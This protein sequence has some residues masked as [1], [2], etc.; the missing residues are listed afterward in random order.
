[1]IGNRTNA[2][3]GAVSGADAR[4]TYTANALNQYMEQTVPARANIMGTAETGTV[5]TVNNQATSRF[6]KYFQS[7]AGVTNS[8]SAAYPLVTVVG[9]LPGGGT[10]GTDV[11]ATSSGHVFVAKTPEQFSYDDDGNLL[12]DGRWS[13]EWDAENRLIGMETRTNLPAA[14]P[15]L[16]LSFAY[17]YMSRRVGKTVHTN[18]SGSW[19]LTSDSSFLYDGWAMISEISYLPSQMQTNQSWFVYGLDLSGT[20]QGAGTIGGLL[21]TVRSGDPEP[22]EGFYAYDA[23]GNVTD[24]GIRVSPSQ[25]TLR[26]VSSCTILRAWQDI[27]EL[28]QSIKGH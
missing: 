25:Y 19:I 6:G 28:R 4:R 26:A 21:A 2:Y 3:D 8:S 17:D 24:L 11:V 14:V 1:L 18:A 9:V 15:R 10:N 16:K 13:Y 7:Y 22:V 27:C 5:V 12:A 23:N 20:L